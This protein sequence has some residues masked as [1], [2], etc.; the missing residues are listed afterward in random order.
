M[1]CTLASDDIATRPSDL[2]MSNFVLNNKKPM[3]AFALAQQPHTYNEA[4]NH[5]Q[6]ATIT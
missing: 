6:E 3:T 2:S 5:L 1:Y 4:L